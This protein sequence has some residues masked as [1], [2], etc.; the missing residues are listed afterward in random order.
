MKWS[1]TLHIAGAVAVLAILGAIGYYSQKTELYKPTL[2]KYIADTDR[3]KAI[4]DNLL[5]ESDAAEMNRSTLQLQLSKAVRCNEFNGECR[6]FFD[7]LNEA[8]NVSSNNQFLSGYQLLLR[9]KYEYLI[10][11]IEDGKMKLKK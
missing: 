7:F 3:L 8:S 5:S 11:A 2:E 10:H 9:K 1:Y 6:A 4:C